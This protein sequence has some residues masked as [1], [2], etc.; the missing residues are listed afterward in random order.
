MPEGFLVSQAPSFWA[1]GMRINLRGP[2]GRGFAVPMS[3]R[4]VALIANPGLSARKLFPLIDI[5]L[6]QDASITLVADLVPDELSSQVEVQPNSRWLDVL[7][8]ADYSALYVERA[9]LPGVM[10]TLGPR[11][12]NIVHGDAQILIDAPVVCGGVADCG[13][14]AI[15]VDSD[16]KM[17]CKDG[18]VFNLFDL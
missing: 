10:E 7:A 16:W 2:L 14:C 4:R 13:V 5:A 1:P 12:Q 6:R 9:S 8:W 11:I 15:R 17:V 3:A 18:P